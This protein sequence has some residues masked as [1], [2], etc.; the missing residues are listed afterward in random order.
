[1]KGK[2][3]LLIVFLV[4]LMSGIASAVRYDLTDF[5][6]TTDPVVMIKELNSLTTPVNLLSNLL[7]LTLFIITFVVFKHHDTRAVFTISAFVTTIVGILFWSIDLIGWSVLAYPSVFLLV[8][9]F[10]KVFG[11]RE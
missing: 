8:A 6:N 2:L 10:Y 11:D 4:L 7:L 3:A 9:V 5:G 1:M